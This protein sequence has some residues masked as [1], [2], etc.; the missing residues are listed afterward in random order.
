MNGRKLGA[1]ERLGMYFCYA[2]A[3]LVILAVVVQNF[4]FASSLGLSGF[5]DI[6]DLA[7]QAVIRR[8]HI[9]F[10]ARELT[11]IWQIND[12]GYGWIYWIFVS[13]TTYPLYILSN[14]YNI[15]WPLLVVPRQLS[16]IFS[17]ASAIVVMRLM[18][19]SGIS[20]FGVAAAV[21]LFILLPA[22]GYFSMRFG[23]V[24]AVLFFAALSFYFAW[25]DAP[26][27]PR[28]RL[29]A[30]LSLAIAGGVKFNG[31]LIA[32]P[33]GLLILLQIRDRS[34][35][36]VARALAMPLLAFIFVFIACV[37]PALFWAPFDTSIWRKYVEIMRFF[38][39]NAA[40]AGT[41]TPF[42]ARIY[43]AVFG[44]F[45]QFI[46]LF[47]LLFGIFIEAVYNKINRNKYVILVLSIFIT[48]FLLG[49]FILSVSGLAL[50][51]TVLTFIYLMGVPGLLR[52]RLGSVII[53]LIVAALVLDVGSRLQR[54]ATAPAERRAAGLD[55]STN[56]W[57][58]FSYFIKN[59]DL[60]INLSRAN[61]VSECIPELNKK[62]WNGHIF[63]DYTIRIR[64]NSLTNPNSCFSVAWGDLSY[65]KKY[66]N[67]QVD[68]LILDRA[69]PGS[70]ADNDYEKYLADKDVA[71]RL[72]SEEDRRTRIE[73]KANKKFGT[74]KVALLCE[75]AE[76]QVFRISD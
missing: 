21:L 36:G 33:V 44:T 71:T 17:I 24:N 45:L 20:K 11:K 39:T 37:N 14:N 67:S 65:D 27:T 32:P 3:V 2:V 13:I 25:A 18:H 9:A 49:F 38:M 72:R 5:R 23:T 26:S 1:L 16:L 58:H 48:T 51:A 61:T 60:T 74:R 41:V 40:A 73:I 10:E 28:G 64:S 50:Y 57:G 8:V 6:D 34:I 30:M 69:S 62:G 76:V 47:A 15:D 53:G 56:L 43:D 19:K 54:L 59:S 55:T 7:F 12:Y 31:L 22:T 70:L 42:H 4:L 52:L 68:Y 35:F 29:L 46:V 63:H 75:T 66:C